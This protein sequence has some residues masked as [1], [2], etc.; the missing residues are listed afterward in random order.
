MDFYLGSS[1]RIRVEAVEDEHGSFQSVVN[2][3]A[4]EAFRLDRRKTEQLLQV[5]LRFSRNSSE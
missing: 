2:Q 5:V 4:A 1:S 3:L